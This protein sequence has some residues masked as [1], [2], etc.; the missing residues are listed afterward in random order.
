LKVKHGGVY[1]MFTCGPAMA[2]AP[3]LFG[4]HL[5]TPASG[6][7]TAQDEDLALGE[8]DG[9][10]QGSRSRKA[11]Y[12]PSIP[13]LG[14]ADQGGHL[15]SSGSS[16]PQASRAGC[17]GHSLSLQPTVGRPPAWILPSPTGG[18][19]V[20][21]LH[22]ADHGC[23]LLFSLVIDPRGASGPSSTLATLSTP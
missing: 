12:W 7:W 2:K 3:G 18:Q 14:W 4:N 9:C 8:Q 11:L 22:S 23:C 6:V 5:G 10:T 13:F 1:T 16:V 15:C 19:R 21:Y 20:F 17:C